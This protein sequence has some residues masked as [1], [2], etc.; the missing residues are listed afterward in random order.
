MIVGVLLIL[1]TINIHP[2]Y[3]D[4]KVIESTQY[5]QG[6]KIEKFFK[7]EDDK[8]KICSKIINIQ[9]KFSNIIKNFGTSAYGEIYNLSF[10]MFL[11]NPITGI[12]IN[13]FKYLCNNNKLYKQMMINYDCASHPH[14]IYIQ[15]LTEGGIIVFIS[16][17]I[18]L[19]ILIEFIFKNIGEREYKIIAITIFL[20]M[21]WPIMSTG[22]LIKNWYGITT[23]FIIGICLCLS[24][25]KKIY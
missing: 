17:F 15:W 11:D 3:N 18:Y 20:T 4:F 1:L 24:K 13:N 16:F 19:Y 10:K 9:P 14:N 25:F 5:H 12:G 6:E 7:C 21:F 22:S 8:K 23:F 2:F